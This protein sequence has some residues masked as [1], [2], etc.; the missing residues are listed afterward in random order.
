MS[1]SIDEL[2]RAREMVESILDELHI[3]AYV[4]EVEPVN[5][6]W[7]IV[8]ECAITEGWERVRFSATRDNLLGSN[9]DAATHLTLIND[10]RERLAACKRKEI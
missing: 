3:E 6:N 9:K 5:Q 2:T 1:V 7:E 10:W 8:I 4:F